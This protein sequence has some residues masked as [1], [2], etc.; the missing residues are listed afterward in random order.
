MPASPGSR[1]RARLSRP[2]AAPSLALFRILFGALLLWDCWRF[3]RDD[4]VWRYWIAPEFHFSYPG[5]AWVGPL[6]K[7]WIELGWL[8][9]GIAALFVML[10]LFYRIAIVA[11]TVIF[12]YLARRGP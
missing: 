7:D 11:L 4:R 2:V 1:I 8:G 12:G 6:S 9:L 5:F 3:I 10:G